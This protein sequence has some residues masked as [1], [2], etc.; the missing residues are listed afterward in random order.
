MS[1]EEKELL[2]HQRNCP[3]PF[4]QRAL[5]AS[6]PIGTLE[7]RGVGG[8]AISLLSLA[9]PRS[10]LMQNLRSM[11]RE[12]NNLVADAR[13]SD[14]TE[15]PNAVVSRRECGEGTEGKRRGGTRVLL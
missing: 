15:H 6:P 3:L 4:L 12:R 2:I 11:N 10:S 14:S 7:P 1:R 8:A 5:G 13:S 9:E